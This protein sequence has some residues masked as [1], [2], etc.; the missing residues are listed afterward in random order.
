MT[1]QEENWVNKRRR[2][3]WDSLPFIIRETVIEKV[4]E[5]FTLEFCENLQKE[6]NKDQDW[7]KEYDHW[8]VE[9]R[10]YL[11]QFFQ[12]SDLPKNDW[13]Y[14]WASAI[15]KSVERVIEKNENQS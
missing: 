4:S 12:D 11:R 10:S 9:L 8:G 3:D 2:E 13:Q 6:I 5:N 1:T 14:Y 15:E 7:W